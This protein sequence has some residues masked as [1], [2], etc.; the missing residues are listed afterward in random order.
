MRRRASSSSE[1]HL[2]LLFVCGRAKWRSPTAERIFARDPRYSCRA[3][4]F[5]SKSGRILHR[6]DVEWA[7]VIF[8][9]ERHHAARLRA[10]HRDWIA[11]RPVHVLYIPD[12]YGF[13]NREL[14]EL[15]KRGVARHL[16]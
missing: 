12:E 4:G 7:D 14:V 2:N 16:P 15:L 10:E 5:S 13:M 11:D 6:S 8:V 9:M 3:R 1:A